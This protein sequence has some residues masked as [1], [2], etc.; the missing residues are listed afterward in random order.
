MAI[1]AVAIAV[2][3][4]PGKG[5]FSLSLA[6]LVALISIWFPRDMND[7]TLGLWHPGYKI[8]APTPPL[9]IAA[10]GWS[11]FLAVSFA[12]VAGFDATTDP[13]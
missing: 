8:D 3:R 9:M 13:G 6:L 7:M 4:L 5:C 12:V 11:I 2:L 10:V 1:P